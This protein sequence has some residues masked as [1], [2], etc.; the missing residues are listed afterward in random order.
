MKIALIALVALAVPEPAP[1]VLDAKQQME[2]AKYIASIQ[3]ERDEANSA[4]VYW[5]EQ[6]KNKKG[7]CI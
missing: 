3:A 5:Y 2:L 4:A 6:W 7:L 1:L